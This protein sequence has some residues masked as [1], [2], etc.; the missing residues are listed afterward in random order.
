MCALKL[1][2]PDQKSVFK[3]RIL[4]LGVGGAGGNAVNNMIQ[5]DLQGVEF[6]VANTDAQ[7]W[8]PWP[9]KAVVLAQIRWLAAL[10]PK[11]RCKTSSMKLA[12]S[13][14]SLSPPAWVV[15]LAPAQRL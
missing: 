6:A 4:V 10:R 7:D 5:A 15:A 1:S 13:T 8:E 2:V 9:H 11:N 3:P 14:W 12:R